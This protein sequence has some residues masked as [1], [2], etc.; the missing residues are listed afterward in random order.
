MSLSADWNAVQPPDGRLRVRWLGQSGFL[1]ECDGARVLLD[2]YLS[3]SLAAKYAGTATPHD[4]MMPVPVKADLLHGIDCVCVSHHHTDHADPWT[5]TG[6]TRNNPAMTLVVPAA[7]ERFILGRLEN[8]PEHVVGLD[9]QEIFET[10]QFRI[11]AIPAAHETTERDEWGRYRYIGYLIR[12]G[13]WSIYHSGDTVW[14]EDLVRALATEPID[15]ALLPINGR[16]KGV[17]G[18][19]DACEAA[20]LARQLNARWTIPCHYGMFAFNTGS[21]ERFSEYAR[22]RFLQIATP[23]CGEVWV[24]PSH[25]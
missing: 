11:R 7:S 10:P 6:I 19:L 13:Q 24:L 15:L 21:A 17:A 9:A 23:P 25:S 18:N 22:E 1:L 2:P 14:H 12:L 8:I 3:D 16:G 5:L 4:R 20:E